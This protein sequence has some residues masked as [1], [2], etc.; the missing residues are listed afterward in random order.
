MLAVG[1][2]YGLSKYEAHQRAKRRR[3]LENQTPDPRLVTSGAG[4]PFAPFVWGQALVGGYPFYPA[5]SYGEQLRFR[6]ISRGECEGICGFD[7]DLQNPT[8]VLG[9][10]EVVRL[11]RVTMPGGDLLR[12]RAG[13]K[14][15]GA[16]EIRE[17]FLANGTQGAGFART[18]PL[19][20]YSTPEYAP[21]PTGPWDENYHE[22]DGWVREAPDPANNKEAGDPTAWSSGYPVWTPGTTHRVQGYSWVAVK[23]VQKK[24]AVDGIEQQA[25]QGAWPEIEFVV[26]GRKV[27]SRGNTAKTWTNNAARVRY[28]WMTEVLGY[29]DAQIDATSYAAAETLCG[30]TIDARVSGQNLSSGALRGLLP[31]VH[32]VHHRRQDHCRGG[33]RGSRV[34]D[35]P[36]LGRRGRGRGRNLLFRAGFR[37]YRHADDQRRRSRRVRAGGHHSAQAGK[38]E[39]QRHPGHCRAEPRPRPAPG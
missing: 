38:P 39:G 31:D 30:Q 11:E 26:R 8:I 5:Q 20:T 22:G 7:G 14:W 34:A 16:I 35:G 1:S 36:G 3:A 12:G 10:E 25:F 4:E 17:F 6:V 33:N 21:G 9:G 18:N 28:D 27:G 2:S 29:T 37:Q 15:E 19:A 32:A 23:F 13:T 24:V